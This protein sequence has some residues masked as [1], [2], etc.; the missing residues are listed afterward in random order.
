[1][2]FVIFPKYSHPN[3]FWRK[4]GKGNP[5]YRSAKTLFPFSDKS[6]FEIKKKE[7]KK[8]STGT[9]KIYENRERE[10]I[11]TDTPGSIYSVSME[12]SNPLAFGIDKIYYSLVL[13]ATEYALLKN[14]WNV[15]VLKENDLVAG[16]S[17]KKA[18]VKLQNSLI[19]GVEDKGNG[20]VVYLA[21]NPLF[22]GFWQNGK[23]LFSNAVFMNK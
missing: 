3:F 2:N 4:F 22:R 11:S 19:F 17:G 15:G 16:F 21:N 9:I 10:E 12:N 6:G 23:L 8:D 7:P 1:M 14:G 5:I 18:Q 20:Q 13:E